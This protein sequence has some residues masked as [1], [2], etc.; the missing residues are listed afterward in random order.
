MSP[1]GVSERGCGRPPGTV[2]IPGPD[3]K[4]VDGNCPSVGVAFGGM[5]AGR[6]IASTWLSLSVIS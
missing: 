1:G 4:A 6:T 2:V 5:P 3:G